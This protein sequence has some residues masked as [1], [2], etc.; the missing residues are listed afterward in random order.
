MSD[1]D[2]RAIENLNRNR[3]V[4]KCACCNGTG[5]VMKYVYPNVADL[6]DCLIC[7]ATG[8]LEKEQAMTDRNDN[9]PN[10]LASIDRPNLDDYDERLRNRDECAAIALKDRVVNSPGLSNL[11]PEGRWEVAISRALDLFEEPR[12]ISELWVWSRFCWAFGRRD[13]WAANAKF[14]ELLKLVMLISENSVKLST[15]P[16]NPK[17]NDLVRTAYLLGEQL[18]AFLRDIYRNDATWNDRADFM[19]FKGKSS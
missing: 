8:K 16:D 4:P 15:Q 3:N 12:N 17:Y 2:D 13:T 7:G 14:E 5:Y 6:C 11:A 9:S 1:I 19:A 10:T 18:E